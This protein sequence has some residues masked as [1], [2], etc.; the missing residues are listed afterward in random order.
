VH[1]YTLFTRLAI[2]F[3]RVRWSTA[4]VMV[5]TGHVQLYRF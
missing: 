1:A 4:F 3:S 2:I 5:T